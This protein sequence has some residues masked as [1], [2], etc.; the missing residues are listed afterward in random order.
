MAMMAD[1][2]VTAFVE[3]NVGSSLAAR[4]EP[5][6]RVFR[7]QAEPLA[8][9][10]FYGFYKFEVAGGAIADVSPLPGSSTKIAV[11]ERVDWPNGKNLPGQGMPNNRVCIIDLTEKGSD[12]VFKKNMCSQLPC[13]Q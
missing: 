5:G 8:F 10:K 3:R 9:E 6:I 1:G 7:V 11:I 4:G 13:H 2:S 12:H